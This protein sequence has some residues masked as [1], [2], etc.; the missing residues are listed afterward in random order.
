MTIQPGPSQPFTSVSLSKQLNWTWHHSPLFCSMYSVP[1]PTRPD[2][3]ALLIPG[4]SLGVTFTVGQWTQV[5]V[6]IQ[7]PVSSNCLPISVDAD[8]ELIIGVR[9]FGAGETSGTR[10]GEFVKYFQSVNTLSEPSSQLLPL[11]L[12]RRELLCKPWLLIDTLPLLVDCCWFSG[13]RIDGHTSVCGYR[14]CCLTCFQATLWP[15][16]TCSLQL[17]SLTHKN[18]S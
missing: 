10:I 17:F 18:K 13:N 14:L 12:F 6:P 4:I 11:Y 1:Q 15:Q 9:C 16:Q 3:S 5:L 8:T 7:S 2:S